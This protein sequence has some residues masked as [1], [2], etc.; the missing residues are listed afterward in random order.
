MRSKLRVPVRE[1]GDD[2]VG[3]VVEIRLIAGDPDRAWAAVVPRDVRQA[4][5]GGLHRLGLC[6]DGAGRV[7]RM[8]PA[9]VTL[10][11]REAH[12]MFER[13]DAAGDRGLRHAERTRCG[14][15]RALAHDREEYAQVGPVPQIVLHF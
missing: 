11:Q 13:V 1:V 7:G 3:R 12:L 15:R 14:Q 6:H 5:G 10:E 2:G 4:R 9:R 8:E